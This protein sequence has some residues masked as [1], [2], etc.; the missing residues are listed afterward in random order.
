MRQVLIR[1]SGLLV[2]AAAFVGADR[3][4][5]AQ[6]LGNVTVGKSEAA[7]EFTDASAT[8]KVYQVSLTF[9]KPVEAPGVKVERLQVWLLSKVYDSPRPGLLLRQI[10]L[11]GVKC[12]D[13]EG[14]FRSQAVTSTSAW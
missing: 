12:D 8:R 1:L 7:V 10:T 14:A 11:D 6:S 5:A 4:A 9:A 13:G 3:P 2:A